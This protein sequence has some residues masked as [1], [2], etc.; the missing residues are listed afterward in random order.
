MN[1]PMVYDELKKKDLTHIWKVMVRGTVGAT[2]AYIAVG[3]F[4]YVTF[5]QRDDVC[6]IM[7]D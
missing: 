2:I 7:D 6:Q 1:V 4:G 5:A 3:V